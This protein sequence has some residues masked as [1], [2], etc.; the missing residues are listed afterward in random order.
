MTPSTLSHDH[1]HD[2]HSTRTIDAPPRPQPRV[3]SALIVARV[4]LA[5]VGRVSS[6]GA[7]A[8]ACVQ[9]AVMLATLGPGLGVCEGGAPRPRG[10]ALE[11][12]AAE[13]RRDPRVP[14]G[15]EH[16]RSH[17]ARAVVVLV[18]LQIL[19]I[20]HRRGWAF[21]L[22]VVLVLELA[23]PPQDHHATNTA[24]TPAQAWSADQP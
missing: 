8:L 7:S 17:E 1:D 22:E 15:A 3:A 2:H 16:G 24:A 10:P 11:L 23:D 12:E 21:A 14:R 5:T 13:L 20:D 4:S 18:L 6:R 9:W 19:V